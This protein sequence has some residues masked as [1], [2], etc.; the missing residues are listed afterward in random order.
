ML[1]ETKTGSEASQIMTFDPPDGT[2]PNAG[3]THTRFSF[4]EFTFTSAALKLRAGL[5]SLWTKN[6][7]PLIKSDEQQKLV[8]SSLL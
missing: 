4:L 8:L 1:T 3:N 2:K 6:H 7:L 5:N